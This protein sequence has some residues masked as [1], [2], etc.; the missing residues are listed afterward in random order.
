M[1][2]RQPGSIPSGC[3]ASTATLW[4]T[5]GAHRGRGGCGSS[6]CLPTGAIRA[7]VPELRGP[8]PV[9]PS[10]LLGRWLLSQGKPLRLRP[11]RV[12]LLPQF[13]ERRAKIVEPLLSYGCSLPRLRKGR[14]ISRR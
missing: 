2:R 11:P 12:A 8:S 4:F 14:G 1:I 5:D 9:P 10:G 7:G 6:S 13:C 3:A